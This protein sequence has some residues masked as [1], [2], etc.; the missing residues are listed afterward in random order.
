[1]A[2]GDTLTPNLNLTKIVRRPHWGV[3]YNT[4]LDLIDTAIGNIQEGI[5][6]STTDANV[7][8]S[9]VTTNNVSASKHGF[10]PKLP[11]DATKYFDGMGGYSVPPTV[12]YIQDSDP[13][14]VG[15]GKTWAN[16]TDVTFAVRNADNT[17][18]VFFS[19]VGD[20]GSGYGLGGYGNIAW[21]TTTVTSGAYTTLSNG[22]KLPNYATVGWGTFLND[23]FTLLNTLMD[24]VAVKEAE[25]GI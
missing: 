2:S 4:N 19:N 17:A 16:L 10:I 6:G 14:A 3:T 21:D 23:N 20:G 9:D 7:A 1:M 15:A 12:N 11:A 22:V 5:G 25:A 13:G 18:W 8:M 24:R